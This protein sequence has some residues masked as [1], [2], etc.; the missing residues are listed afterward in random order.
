M[1]RGALGCGIA[2]CAALGVSI[3]AA[4][5]A[6]GQGYPDRPVRIISDSA[7]GSAIDSVLRILGDRFSQMWGQQV[8]IV[9]QPGAGGALSARAAAAAEPD[10]Y[11]LFMPALSLFLDLPGKAANLPLELPRDVV[12]IGSVIVQPMFVA[13]APALG[14]STLPQLIALAK[15]RP[16]EISYAATG[17]GRITHLTGEL[18]ARRAGIKL[19]VV[20]YS[21]GPSHALN[22]VIAGRIGIIIEGYPGLAGAIQG[23][24]IK[25][26][27][28]GS[29]QRLPEFPDLPTVAETLPG[30]EAA[31][32]QG[33]AAPPHTPDPIVRKV[34]DDLRKAVEQPEVQQQFALRGGY[35]APMTP[36]EVIAFVQRQQ[37]LWNPLLQALATATK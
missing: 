26:I 37:Q 2:L 15:G 12:P 1:Q 6:R 36:A 28:V 25:A 35:A 10:G 19:V 9:N 33:L 16:G 17:I 8:V 22:D 3:A 27:A 24:A 20:P 14:V 32:W 21:G 34:A 11:T 23:G 31:G 30:F 13:V 7:P 18:I 5:S 29:P 4:T